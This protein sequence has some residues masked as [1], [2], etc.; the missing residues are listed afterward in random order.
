[1]TDAQIVLT[2]IFSVPA[3]LSIGSLLALWLRQLPERPLYR[4]GVQDGCGRKAAARA[5][6]K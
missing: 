3:I 4:Y 2:A 1:M 5:R 6:G